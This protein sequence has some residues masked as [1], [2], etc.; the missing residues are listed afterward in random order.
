[1]APLMKVEPHPCVWIKRVGVAGEK[2]T[3]LRF[4]DF[5]HWPRSVR[6]LDRVAELNVSVA[7]IARDNESLAAVD[8]RDVAGRGS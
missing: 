3:H 8:S 5:G 7:E 4:G 1:M 6:K 2:P